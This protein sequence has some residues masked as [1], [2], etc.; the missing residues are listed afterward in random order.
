MKL[1]EIVLLLAIIVTQNVKASDETKDLTTLVQK[2]ELVVMEG[3]S[4]A[5]APL[6]L[7]HP[8]PYPP[9]P[10]PPRQSPYPGYGSYYN[11]GRGNDGW[12]HC[13]EWASNGGVLNNGNPVGDYFCEQR[14]PSYYNWGTGGDGWGYCYQYTPNGD[15]LNSGSPVGNYYCDQRR[16]SYYAWG[17]GYDGYTHCYQYTANGVAMNQGQAVSDYYC[18]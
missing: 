12:G 15:A 11:W 5:Q 18:R 8:R 14:N 1:R 3:D 16:P 2:K 6:F 13:Y 17:R 10:P 4:R 7:M 9:P